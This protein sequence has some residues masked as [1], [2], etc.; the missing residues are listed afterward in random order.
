MVHIL[1]PKPADPTL[2]TFFNVDGVVGAPP[3][4]NKPEDVVFIQFIFRFAADHPGRVAPELLPVLNAVQVT[5]SIDAATINAIRATQ[6]RFHRNR[7]GTIVDGRVSPAHGYSYGSDLFTIV[8]Y[9]NI[10]QEETKADWPRLD[11]VP[12]CP[13]ALAAAVIREVVGT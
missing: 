6:E 3:A 2:P 8:H 7:P 1:A 9:N 10:L 4:Q 12:G 11:K 13:P 5:G